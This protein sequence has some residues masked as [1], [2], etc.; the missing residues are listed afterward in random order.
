MVQKRVIIAF[1]LILL[2]AVIIGYH[3]INFPDHPKTPDITPQETPDDTLRQEG[4]P[5]TS[6]EEWH[7]RADEIGYW[8]EGILIPGSLSNFDLLVLLRSKGVPE[9]TEFDRTS[10]GDL[11]WK[12]H[13]QILHHY[14]EGSRTDAQKPCNHAGDEH[15]GTPQAGTGRVIDDTPA[16]C[17]VIV[18]A[19]KPQP[20]G[21]AILPIPGTRLP[22]KP[23]LDDEGDTSND[24]D[25]AEGY[26]ENLPA[27][28]QGDGGSNYRTDDGEHLQIHP[29]LEVDQ[30][31]AH[32]HRC[33]AAGGGND[34]DHACGNGQLDIH[35]QKRKDRNDHRPSAEA[36]H[37]TK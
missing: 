20:A 4:K 25:G 30:A 29:H 6:D 22:G 19:R 18:A 32:V 36:G 3:G 15:Q 27:G 37:G 13:G 1:L 8:A 21:E 5:C 9:T 10:P 23:L 24:E 31:L 33:G 11:S 17:P 34:R 35:P 28:G 12:T 26:E 7:Q 14:L 16:F 2:A